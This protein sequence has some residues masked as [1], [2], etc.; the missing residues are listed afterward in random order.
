MPARGRRLLAAFL[1]CASVLLLALSA[2]A[3]AESMTSDTIHHNLVVTIEPASHKL[4]AIDTVTLPESMTGEF[5]FSL[6]PGLRLIPGKT[7]TFI[8]PL[9]GG[10]EGDQRRYSVA[11]PPGQHNFTVAYHGEI[12]HP[13]EGYGSEQ[14]RGFKVTRGLIAP[15][16]VYLAGRS[17]WYPRMGESLVR[18]R[19]EV[20]V[21]ESWE[22]VSQ[23][24]PVE[25]TNGTGKETETCL[26]SA[27]AV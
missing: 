24:N 23:G 6:H 12:H 15:E 1:V 2:A 16:G 27:L 25:R 8:R 7:D 22:A 20:S 10:G 14:A 17:L 5:V 21:P 18:F 26:R 3:T 4:S 11:L 19:M 9:P 13:L